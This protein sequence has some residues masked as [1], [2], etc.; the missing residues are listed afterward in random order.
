MYTSLETEIDTLYIVVENN[1]LS[2]I[3]IG[4]ADFLANEDMS[5]VT[6]QSENGLLLECVTQ[7]KE[8]FRGKRNHFNLP[9]EPKG[10]NFQIEVWKELADIPFGQTKSYQDIA[11]AVG[12]PKAVRAV[13]Q[14]NKANRIPIVIP[15]HRVIGKNQTLTG[16]AGSRKE[17]KNILLT[18]EGASFIRERN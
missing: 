3:Y 13:G 16:Y 17:I 11:I 1:R 7:L 12:R 2:A 9:I 5:L 14:A 15:C 8:Y 18:I 6:A 10:T 4:E